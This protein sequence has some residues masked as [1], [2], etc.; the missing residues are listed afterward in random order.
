MVFPGPAVWVGHPT[1]VTCVL[2][3]M[4]VAFNATLPCSQWCWPLLAPGNLTILPGLV[5]LGVI[6]WPAD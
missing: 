1:A 2:L 3:P 4:T 5:E 6:N